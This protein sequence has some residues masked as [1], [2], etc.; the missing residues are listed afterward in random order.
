MAVFA[1]IV[2]SRTR[3]A[4]K[5]IGIF[6]PWN[7]EFELVDISAQ[8][9]GDDGMMFMGAVASESS[10]YDSGKIIFVPGNAHSVGVFDPFNYNFHLVDLPTEINIAM[11]MKWAEGALAPNGKIIFAP[12]NADAVGVFD[13]VEYNYYSYVI[14]YTNCISIYMYM[15]YM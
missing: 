15:H 9:H 10:S 8:I 3:R 4:T 11:E 6:S 5:V 13:P 14:V 2:G 7:D 12:F 1:V